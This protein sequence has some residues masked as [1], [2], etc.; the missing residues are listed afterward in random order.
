ML[1]P[2]SALVGEYTYVS[3]FDDALD[4]PQP[5]GDDADEDAQKAYQKALAAFGERWQ[6]YL[7]GAAEAPLKADAKPTL[8][9]LRQ[10]KASEA[11]ELVRANAN[12]FDLA[13]RALV[14]ISGHAIPGWKFARAKDADGREAANVDDAPDWL[15]PV[16]AEVGGRVLARMHPS[17]K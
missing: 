5:P 15:W 14:G 4:R 1:R 7:D 10:L 12:G 2:Q 9:H 8:F 3:A 16:L 11:N 6:Q 13:R 17:G